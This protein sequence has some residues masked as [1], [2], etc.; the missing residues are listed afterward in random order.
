MAKLSK[1]SLKE[2]DTALDQLGGGAAPVP[3]PPT[4]PRVAPSRKVA[5]PKAR[6]KK[7]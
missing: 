6:A 1:K 2:F 7:R 5:K 4:R 3:P